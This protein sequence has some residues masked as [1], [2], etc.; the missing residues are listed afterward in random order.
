M[1]MYFSTADFLGSLAGAIRDVFTRPTEFFR[2]MPQAT[3]YKDG[4]ILLILMLAVPILLGILFTTGGL[5]LHLLPVILLFGIPVA[6]AGAWLWAWYLGWAVRTFTSG[7]L[8]TRDAFLLYAY[9]NI[10]SLFSWVPLI[11]VVMGIWSIYLE[12]KGLTAYAGV[13]GGKALLIIFVPLIVLAVS[14]AV[15]AVLIGVFMSQSPQPP[16]ERLF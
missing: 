10:P 16:V 14:G 15:L 4:A 2:Q 9:S 1:P 12:W 5:A 3:S 7:Q 6:L 8:S 11:N 13:S